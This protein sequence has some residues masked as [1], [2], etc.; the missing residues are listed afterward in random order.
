MLKVGDK[1]G[2]FYLLATIVI[3]ALIVGVFAITNFTS[4]KEESKVKQ[5][6][7]E[8]D[9]ESEKILELGATTGN[10][11]WY[12]FTGN[13]SK[14]AGNDVVIFYAIKNSSYEEA[15]KYDENG[16]KQH[17]Y[18]ISPGDNFCYIGV[19]RYYQ[20]KIREGQNFYY[21]I[22]QYINNEKYV[23]TNGP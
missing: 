19:D 15:F 7:K 22:T 23:A 11:P 5:L 12:D 16:Q 17:V 10:Y 13:F 1:M 4:T 20:F 8:L 14:Y 18:S 3:L 6:A 9:S 2:Q 21:V